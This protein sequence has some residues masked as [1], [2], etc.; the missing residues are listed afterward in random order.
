MNEQ[1]HGQ[2]KWL[3]PWIVRI[4]MIGSLVAVA[5]AAVLVAITVNTSHKADERAKRNDEL[6]TTIAALV[7]DV[8]ALRDQVLTN[9]DTPVVQ[10]PTPAVIAAAAAAGGTGAQGD[11]GET[12]AAG[13]PGGTGNTGAVGDT[14]ARGDTGAAGNTGAAGA[15]GDTGAA[16]QSITGPPGP[17]GENGSVGP[18]GPQGNQGPP[19]AT[20]TS[21]TCTPTN[22]LD[23]GLPW[24]CIVP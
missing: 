14:G 7:A 23:L 6:S 1:L 3:K 19:G 9:G 8:Q 16:G 13:E 21:F 10:A 11:T 22:P 2:P 18:Q 4:P 17:Q 24:I 12:G 5:L 20:P 15:T